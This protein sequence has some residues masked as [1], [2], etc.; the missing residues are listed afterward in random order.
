MG[1]LS[2]KAV[3]WQ[4]PSCPSPGASLAAV[5]TAVTLS[6]ERAVPAAFVT[7]P[8]D[9][10]T[11][12]LVSLL[13]GVTVALAS[14]GG[15]P[16]VPDPHAVALLSISKFC[17]EEISFDTRRMKQERDMVTDSASTKRRRRADLRSLSR[18][19]CLCKHRKTH[20][21]PKAGFKTQHRIQ[22]LPLG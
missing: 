13:Q 20:R 5:T 8:R 6:R 3:G 10:S 4:A 19:S 15:N 7:P 2:L 11:G 9:G 16:S 22:H 18:S 21:G 14:L 17:P 12:E 1:A